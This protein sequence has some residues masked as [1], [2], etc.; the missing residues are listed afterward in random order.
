MDGLFREDAL[1]LAGPS[2]VASFFRNIILF[3]LELR[4]K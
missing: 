1:P 4:W 3:Y 2:G